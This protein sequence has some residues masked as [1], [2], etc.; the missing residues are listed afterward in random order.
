MSGVLHHA[1]RATVVGLV[2]CLVPLMSCSLV[3]DWN[4]Y[5]GGDAGIVVDGGDAAPPPS[6]GPQSCSGCCDG[7]RCA[8]GLSATTCGQG[9]QACQSCADQGLLCSGGACT[10]PPVDS[11]PSP[12][13]SG[14]PCSLIACKTLLTCLASID[15]ACCKP[16]GTCGCEAVIGPSICH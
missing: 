8:D 5:T 7:T 6:C 14:P 2:A 16:D 10:V 4:G 11:G 13:D 9:G 1:H 12:P 15:I 3:L